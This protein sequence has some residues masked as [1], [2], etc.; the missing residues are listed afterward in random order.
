[1]FIDHVNLNHIRVFEC[2][3]RTRSMTQAA[4]ELHLTQSGVSQ[5]IKSLEDML[6]VQLF[7]RIQQ[8][9]V[10][11]SAGALLFKKSSQGLREIEQALWALKG[12][13]QQL[14]GNVTIGMPTEFGNNLVL[15]LLA[16][17]AKKH[18]LIHFKLNLGLASAM[19]AMLLSGEV[20]F[21]FVDDFRM[22]RRIKIE[23][24]YDETLELCASEELIKRVGAPK[25]TRKFFE[26]LEYVEYQEDEP[27]LR[28]WFAHHLHSKHIDLNVR[29]TVMD[30]Q[31]L[32]RLIVSEV[33]AGILPSHRVTKLEQQGQRLYRFKGCGKPLKNT[34]SIA[35]LTERTH[36]PPTV[37]TIEALKAGLLR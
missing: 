34:I 7:D 15:P 30:V 24:V 12:A 33:G 28:K 9:L 2:V 26:S 20:D 18:P 23:R 19:N 36:T 4:Q 13:D 6:G 3:Y 17:I 32:A 14:S 29:A 8:K 35:Y 11:T 1:M 22:D 16:Q 25:N 5:H 10:A 37:A 21:A 27:V 31:A